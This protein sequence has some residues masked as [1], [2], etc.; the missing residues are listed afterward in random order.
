MPNKLFERSNCT[1]LPFY[2]GGQNL[3]SLG[4]AVVRGKGPVYLLGK[5]L[6]NLAVLTVVLSVLTL[7]ALVMQWVRAEDPQ[8][9]LYK[10]ASP[11]WLMGVPVLAVWSAFAVAFESIPFLR[12]SLG[13]AVAFFLWM[14]YL[15]SWAPSFAS[16]ATPSKICQAYRGRRLPFS[17]RFLNSTQPRIFARAVCSGFRCH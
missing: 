8:V 7:V 16:L 14:G 10:L 15:S 17:T 9:S 2:K 13:N 5:W 3:G 1:I 11:I 6:S 12:G 4:L